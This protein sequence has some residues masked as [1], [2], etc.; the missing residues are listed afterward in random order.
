MILK[1]T[2]CILILLGCWSGI[3][4]QKGAVYLQNYPTAA[5]GIKTNALVQTKQKN[6]LLANARGA[7][8]YNG[9]QWQ[10][11]KANAT[12]YALLDDST[13]VY[14]GGRSSFGYLKLE[15]SLQYSFHSLSTSNKKLPKE[16]GDFYFVKGNAKHVYFLS[17][18]LLVEV[19]RAERKVRRIWKDQAFQSLMVF[20]EKVWVN[21]EGKGLHQIPTDNSNE[22][23][24]APVLAKIKTNIDFGNL[25]VK[26]TFASSQ[27]LYVVAQN[28]VYCYDGA[29]WTA[30]ALTAQK[31]LEEHSLTQGTLLK[32]GA[33]ALG[34][35]NGGVVVVDPASGKTL[36][37][38][39]HQT[40]LPDDEVQ[41]LAADQQQG[42]WIVHTQ[43]ISRA[44]FS[45]PVSNFSH[46]PGLVGN[47]TSV[48]YWKNQLYVATSEGLFQL[49]KTRSFQDL[50][51][52]IK[53]QQ[54]A[55]GNQVLVRSETAGGTVVGNLINN[56][57]GKKKKVSVKVQKPQ[58]K[59]PLKRRNLLQRELY[60]LSSFPY[61]YHKVSG[62]S[63]RVNQIAATNDALLLGSNQG[64]YVYQN[65][66]VVQVLK[67]VYIHQVKVSPNNAQ[68]AY[69]ATNEGL[70]SVVKQGN[71]WQLKDN[72]AAI[73]AVT[74]SIAFMGNSL[75]LGS[76][77][78]AIRAEVNQGAYQSHKV[79][80]LPRYYVENV[81][82][83]VVGQK[84]VLFLSNGMYRL[85]AKKQEFYRDSLLKDVRLPYQVVQQQGVWTNLQQR[86]TNV[87][88]SNQIA[89][90]NL[91]KQVG[92]IYRD[93][94][95]NLWVIDGQQVF[96]MVGA[97]AK[98][99]VGFEVLLTKVYDHRQQALDIDDI[100]LYQGAKTIALPLN[101]GL[102][103]I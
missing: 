103:I 66:A 68:L 91:C 52:P 37:T 65:G 45:V 47:P 57:F 71:T 18:Q 101:W 86:W 55:R 1:K 49:K 84:P 2:L 4:A 11:I 30:L 88:D 10:H 29:K 72:F 12:L 94:A 63:A 16:V 13:V 40:G 38:I 98:D 93:G 50:V 78:Q 41:T 31:Y 54:A 23:K 87:S 97:S 39:N 28:K 80:K 82:V 53:I 74:Y 73:K 36:H 85:D 7:A 25:K 81:Q 26:S 22:D 48:T 34:T 89:Y 3:Y 64:L 32:S 67:D 69:V 60:A 58:R 17:N 62:F 61:F 70:K 92:D 95:Q 14:T 33:L 27:Y 8:Q 44:I 90:L 79:Y 42:L 20:K 51:N 99:S 9:Q 56:V 102:R 77:N 100:R 59:V 19:D 15:P 43:G 21:I 46:Y 76:D 5:T 6:I 24:K 35:L 75:W 96:K 83:A